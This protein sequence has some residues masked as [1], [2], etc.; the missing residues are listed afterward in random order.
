M[1]CAERDWKLYLAVAAHSSLESDAPLGR[2]KPKDTPGSIQIWSVAPTANLKAKPQPTYVPAPASK[3]SA[4]PKPPPPPKPATPGAPPKKRG[5]PRKNQDAPIRVHKPT[6]KSKQAAQKEGDEGDELAPS[7]EK[8]PSEDVDMQEPVTGPSDVVAEE[9][10]A[11]KDADMEEAPPA[12]AP[13]VDTEANGPPP[14]PT[15]WPASDEWDMQMK[16]E[17]V[18]CF[19]G[20]MPSKLQWCP[21]GSSDP[22]RPALFP[23]RQ[24]A[25]LNRAYFCQITPE[26][27]SSTPKLGVLAGTFEDGSV[28]IFA[29]PDPDL[30]PVT[31]D[32]TQPGPAYGALYSSF[33]PLT[34][35]LLTHAD[36]RLVFAVHL[37]PLTTLEVDD[38][39]MLCLDWGSDKIL[40][41]GLSNGASDTFVPLGAFD[42]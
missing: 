2:T 16:L 13:D 9:P 41:T 20:G 25:R 34:H 33:R 24:C 10:K 7:P 38:A 35:A 18:V 3:H 5:R 12:P 17:M 30:L 29:V 1:L 8:A 4:R 36:S 40:A 23:H 28:K 22:V 27:S 39:T 15:S 14:E 21:T 32:S 11:E 26:S 6:A 19:E 37:S 31:A 42:R